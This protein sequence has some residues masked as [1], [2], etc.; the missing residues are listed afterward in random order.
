MRCFHL[1]AV[2]FKFIHKMSATLTYKFFT[3]SRWDHTKR[4]DYYFNKRIKHAVSDL[5][6]DSLRNL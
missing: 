2:M 6:Q 1:Q 5:D 3:Y 4:Q